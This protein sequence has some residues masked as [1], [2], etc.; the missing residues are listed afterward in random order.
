MKELFDWLWNLP[1]VWFIGLGVALLLLFI[2]PVFYWRK[3]S[4]DEF[5]QRRKAARA[6]M[7]RHDA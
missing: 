4:L 6:R 1:A 5:E 7:G 3:K 2:A